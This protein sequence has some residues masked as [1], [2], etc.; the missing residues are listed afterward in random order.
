MRFDPALDGPY[1]TRDRLV[2]NDE[3]GCRYVEAFFANGGGDEHVDLAASETI[4][5]RQLL[6]L[7]H[8]LLC[9]SRG[10]SD[11]GI[12]FDPV[13]LVEQGDQSLH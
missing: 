13:V 12:R 4:Q 1:R 8:A 11:E 9:A 3:V 2:Q 6:F 5:L 7:R 10:L